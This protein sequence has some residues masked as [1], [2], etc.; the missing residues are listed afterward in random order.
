MAHCSRPSG[1]APLAAV[2]SHDAS[3]AA[4]AD[5]EAG[6]AI[7]SASGDVEPT[8]PLD[9]PILSQLT[10][11]NRALDRHDVAALDGLYAQD[12][13]FYGQRMTKSAILESKRRALSADGTFQQQIVG[14]IQVV[15][16]VSGESAI[17]TF[18]KRSGDP[19][20]L[21]DVRAR[22]F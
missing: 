16:V 4:S 8:T 3:T 7:S 15:A 11:W 13:C 17:A 19:G 12:V 2:S 21:Q 18:V 20:H 22:I 14:D 5:L 10:A 1:A 6:L 9:D